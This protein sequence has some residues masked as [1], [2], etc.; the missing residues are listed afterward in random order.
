L[1]FFASTKPMTTLHQLKLNVVLTVGRK[2]ILITAV[3]QEMSG[4][5]VENVRELLAPWQRL[6]GATRH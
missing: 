3:M 4:P 2:G 1:F 6:S 5:G